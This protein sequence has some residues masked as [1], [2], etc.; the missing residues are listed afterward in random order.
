MPTSAHPFPVSFRWTT[1][2]PISWPTFLCTG[3]SDW[4]VQTSVARMMR[5]PPAFTTMVRVTSQKTFL[6]GSWPYTSTGISMITLELRRLGF[7][8]DCDRLGRCVGPARG[9]RSEVSARVCG[10]DSCCDIASV[11]RP[12]R[13][14]KSGVTRQAQE[15]SVDLFFEVRRGSPRELGQPLFLHPEGPLSQLQ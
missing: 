14:C 10:G 7:Q 4:L 2:H 6:S 9:S 13:A 12:S 3:S 1:W 15:E 11:D 5:A 8:V